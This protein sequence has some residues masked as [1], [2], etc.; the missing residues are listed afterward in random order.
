MQRVIVKEFGGTENLIV[1]SVDEL[2]GSARV[3]QVLDRSGYRAM[4]KGSS[5][6]QDEERLANVEELVTAARQ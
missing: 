6:P 3:Q 4:L 2:G 1:E 5:D